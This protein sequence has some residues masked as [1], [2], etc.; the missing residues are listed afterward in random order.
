MFSHS[1]YVD[2]NREVGLLKARLRLKTR[3]F[4]FIIGLP[5][6][7]VSRIMSAGLGEF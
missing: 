1:F 3:G 7:T 2:W 4:Y 6:W 5:T